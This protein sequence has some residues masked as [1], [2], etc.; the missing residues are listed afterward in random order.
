MVCPIPQ[1]NHNDQWH[2]S[3]WK[4]ILVESDYCPVLP[5]GGILLH[6]DGTKRRRTPRAAGGIVHGRVDLYMTQVSIASVLVIRQH[7]DLDHERTHGSAGGRRRLG[8]RGLVYVDD[9]PA[10]RLIQL[11]LLKLSQVVEVT[12]HTNRQ[13]AIHSYNRTNC[14]YDTAV[15]PAHINFFS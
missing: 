8:P 4:P 1:G 12:A 13:P 5:N 15:K 10:W 9:N 14:N 11:H 3:Y 7:G 2:M 6:V